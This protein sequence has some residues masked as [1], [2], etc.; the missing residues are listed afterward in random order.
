MPVKLSGST[1][2]FVTLE[3]PAVAGSNTITLPANS[4]TVITTASTN[5]I[6]IAAIQATGTPSAST[7]LLGSGAW[8][9]FGGTLL[10]A[11]QYLTTGT[12]Y[13][14]PAG[15][16]AIY[17]EL[18]GAGAGAGSATGG[19]SPTAGGGGGG[20]AYAAKYFLV[21]ASTAYAY[22]IGNG[23]TAGTL[24]GNGGNG[25]NTTLTVG[26]V[27]VT[28]GGG[29]G[30]QGGGGSGSGGTATNG[31][32]NIPGSPGNI[33]A[34]SGGGNFFFP[35]NYT[36]GTSGSFYGQGGS[37]RASGTNPVGAGYQGFI[38]IWEYS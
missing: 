20:G 13:T 37:G 23:G 29:T 4:G 10:R 25:G 16:T 22:A 15:C 35:P 2:G 14:T 11:P 6:P 26:A 34:Y 8:G 9:A 36:T 38:R 24:G 19:G 30:G 32:L 18:V 12:S 31:D 33:L 27:T 17:V 28:A 1:S 21:S 5:A 3:A 7:V